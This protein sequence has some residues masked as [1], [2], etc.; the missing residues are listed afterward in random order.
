[1]LGAH[2]KAYGKWSTIRSIQRMRSH[3]V[4]VQFQLQHQT[5][6]QCAIVSVPFHQQDVYP[7]PLVGVVAAL[8][9]SRSDRGD[10]KEQIRAVKIETRARRNYGKI[11]QD[12][13]AIGDLSCSG[14]AAIISRYIFY[15]NFPMF[16]PNLNICSRSLFFLCFTYRMCG[17]N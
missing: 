14:H 8:N 2:P 4:N 6:T 3:S 10:F 7:S 1:M 5:H 17:P 16:L 13:A 9:R 11:L 15:I 12:G